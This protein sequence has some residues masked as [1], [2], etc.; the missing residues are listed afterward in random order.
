M[1][2]LM[3]PRQ[4]TSPSGKPDKSG[5]P[6]T[7]MGE[8]KTTL[9]HMAE[10][11]DDLTDRDFDRAFYSLMIPHHQSSI[12]M[13]EKVL[14][15]PH[16]AQVETWARQLVSQQKKEIDE[17]RHALDSVG[18]SDRELERQAC[19]KMAGMVAMQQNDRDFVSMMIPHHQ[20]GIRM[21]QCAEARTDNPELLAFANKMITQE[22]KEIQQFQN[23]LDRH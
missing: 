20:S 8:M 15:N 1:E 14:E 4:N 3:L 11:L 9:Q 2:N 16:D 5:K 12:D 18:G 23:W 19:S 6:M 22:K 13:A 21:A 10:P 7:S 17:M